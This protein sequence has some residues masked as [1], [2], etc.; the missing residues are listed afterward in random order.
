MNLLVFPA[1]LSWLML[2]AIIWLFIQVWMLSQQVMVSRSGIKNRTELENAY[3]K[4]MIGPDEYER[5][6]G[7]MR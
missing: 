7:S 4:G 5:L 3:V 1:W 2:L 6:K